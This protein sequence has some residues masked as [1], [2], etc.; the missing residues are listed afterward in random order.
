MLL[1]NEPLE[2]VRTPK[3]QVLQRLTAIGTSVNVDDPSIEDPGYLRPQIGQSRSLRLS[4]SPLAEAFI[5]DDVASQALGDNRC[6]LVGATEITGIDDFDV[7]FPK[8]VKGA[9]GLSVS[10]A[11]ESSGVRLSLPPTELIP[12]A[13]PVSNQPRCRSGLNLFVHVDHYG[14][15]RLGR[16]V[17]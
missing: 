11:G 14:R 9:M 10:A 12:R 7:F 15:R 4:E 8:G 3:V 5:G 6:G 17:D 16:S 1:S 13:L 2:K